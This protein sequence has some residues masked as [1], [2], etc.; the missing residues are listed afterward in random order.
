MCF[1]PVDGVESK[2]SDV[3]RKSKCN[4]REAQ[5][6][7]RIVDLLQERGNLV[8]KQ[9]AIITPYNGQVWIA[10]IATCSAYVGLSQV[11]RVSDLA[12]RRGMGKVTVS[13]VDGFQGREK[14]VIIFSAVRAND[15]GK[16]GFL[17]DWK[18]LNVALTRARFGIIVLG[19]ENKET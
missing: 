19:M 15:K 16:V 12:E 10:L 9:I 13:S 18:R 6:A 3:T 11:K 2:S 8:Q 1:V 4:E 17:S 5:L 7:L 14:D